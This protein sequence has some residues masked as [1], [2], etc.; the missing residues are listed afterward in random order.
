MKKWRIHLTYLTMLPLLTIGGCGPKGGSVKTAAKKASFELEAPLPVDP[1]VTH[2]VL[3]NGLKYFI[4]F[5]EEPENRAEL[6]LV[7]HA[8]SVLEDEDQIGLAHFLEHMAFNGTIN[9]PSNDLVHY[10]ESLGSRFGPDLNAHTSFDE[11][12]YKL[13][14]PTDDDELFANAFLVL[15][16]WAQ[17]MV[18]TS[19]EIEKERGVVLEEYRRTRGAMGRARDALMPLTFYEAKH[20]DRLPI[21]TE[22]SLTSFEH[23]AVR[24]FYAEWYRPDLMAVMVVGDFDVDEVEQR[25]H[26]HFG[27]LV[28]PDNPRPRPPLPI[29]DHEET[30]VGIIADPE[31]TTSVVSLIHKVDWTNGQLHR[32]YRMGIVEQLVHDMINGRLWELTQQN[33]PPFVRGGVGRTMLT[34]ERSTREAG[35]LVMEQGIVTGL[36]AVLIEL[37]R[38]K[39]HGFADGELERAKQQALRNIEKAFEERENT[40]SR[41][42]VD[43]LTRHFLTNEAIPGLAYELEM[44]RHWLPTICIDEVNGFAHGW[45][46]PHSRVLSVMLPEKEGL[47]APKEDELRHVLATVPQLKLTPYEDMEVDEPLMTETPAPGNIVEEKHL[48]SLQVTE[49]T[50]SNGIRVVLRPTDFKKDEIRFKGYSWGGHSLAADEDYI[51]AVSAT[52]IAKKSGI[53]PFDANQLR[54]YFA[55]K[56]VHISPFLS[57]HRQGITGASSVRDL[58]LAFQL[59]HLMFRAPRFDELAFDLDR[60]RRERNLLN[61]LNDPDAALNDAYHA[62]TWD[63]HPRKIS[64]TVDRLDEMNLERSKMIFEER[65]RDPGEFAFFFV[66]A[67]DKETIEPLI[68]TYLAS[69]PS[70]DGEE[71]WRDIGA[72]RLPGILRQEVHQ[73]IEQKARVKIVFHGEMAYVRDQRYRLAALGS[74]LKVRLREK[75]REELGGAYSVGVST[76]SFFVPQAGYTV[77]IDFQCDPNRLDALVQ[78]L[79]NEIGSMQNELGESR[80]VESLKEQQRRAFETSVESNKW[81]LSNLVTQDERGEDPENILLYL[82]L[83]EALTDEGIQEAAKLYLNVQQYVQV[84]L[85]PGQE[86]G[87]DGQGTEQ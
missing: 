39:Q 12:V 86:V 54:R 50:L 10:L 66:G 76:S 71:T 26:E 77:S 53:G 27:K 1:G 31:V 7:V 24:R 42:H 22:E 29:P 44:Y 61:R 63:N 83:V 79:F 5:N 73:G 49:L 11:T 2:G 36:E 33:D 38:A 23:D 13:Q 87:D 68:K 60:T 14:V 17:G 67:F 37:E 30:L 62:L 84:V 16:D 28:N 58:E 15:E 64:W 20:A 21:G 81:W 70:I 8:G 78:D 41:T 47:E 80:F 40:I 18:L 6:R 72:R 59:L 32:D 4:E 46:G 69:L 43:E 34:P 65:F 45:L 75:I 35:A 74:V 51:A 19:E 25:I 56:S 9:F 85:R 3:D 48:D 52:S 82:D 57:S 55:G